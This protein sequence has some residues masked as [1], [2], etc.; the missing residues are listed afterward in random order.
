MCWRGVSLVLAVG[1]LVQ[2]A[3][4]GRAAAAP[5]VTIAPPETYLRGIPS[6][7]SGGTWYQ[8]TDVTANRLRA[9]ITFQMPELLERGLEPGPVIAFWQLLV[10]AS[11]IAHGDSSSRTVG[12]VKVTSLR[13]NCDFSGNC[14]VRFR[15]EGSTDAAEEATGLQWVSQVQ[16]GIAITIVRTFSGDSRV[17]VLKPDYSVDGDGGTL[18]HPNN[19]YGPLITSNLLIAANASPAEV[20]SDKFHYAADEPLDWARRLA[21]AIAAFPNEATAEPVPINV[22]VPE[23]RDTL[24]V[25]LRID[26]SDVCPPTRAIVFV[27]QSSHAV[28]GFV[29]VGGQHGAIADLSLELGRTWRIELQQLGGA[30]INAT[31]L[32]TVG[33]GTGVRITGPLRCADGKGV[34][35]QEGIAQNIPDPSVAAEG[36]LTADPVATQSA[37]VVEDP[38]PGAQPDPRVD[39]PAT[40]IS[41]EL[42]FAGL[43]ALAL[44]ISIYLVIALRRGDHSS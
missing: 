28:G 37:L 43:L 32:Q 5:S 24:H 33:S 1:F 14:A 36:G 3:A 35:T 11:D 6:D 17:E 10:T 39:T 44:G 41:I 30:V 40:G 18:A 2:V 13:P 34:F 4:P 27:D 9:D 25:Q 20:P 12:P 42:L 22:W 26:F 15:L 29:I 16:L 19:M 7:V 21:D 31:Q 23:Q 38:T 8:A